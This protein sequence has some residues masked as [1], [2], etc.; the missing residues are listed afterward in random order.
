MRRVSEQPLASPGVVAWRTR[1]LV[2]IALGAGLV[3]VGLTLMASEADPNAVDLAATRWLQQLN[4]PVFA[5]FMAD[6][7]WFGFAPQNWAIPVVLA[8]PFALRRLWVEALWVLG[9][10]AASLVAVVLKEIVNR[11]RPSPDLVGVLSPLNTRASPAAT[12]CNTPHFSASCSSSCT[13]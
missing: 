8:A 13:Y 3:L 6:V 4:S 1:H 10:Q 9:S 2:G 12:S 11:P 7:S 5:A